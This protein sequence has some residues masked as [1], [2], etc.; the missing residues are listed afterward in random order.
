MSKDGLDVS[1]EVA[2]LLSELKDIHTL[3]TI[4][5]EHI[6]KTVGLVSQ[7]DREVKSLFFMGLHR[8]AMDISNFLLDKARQ[9]EEDIKNGSGNDGSG[10][11][12]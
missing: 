7:S 10:I 4:D 1:K 8:V 5:I 9:I 3:D 6:S 2:K 11:L 12:N